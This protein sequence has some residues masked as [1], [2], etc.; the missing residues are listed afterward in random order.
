MAECDRLMMVAGYDGAAQ[1]ALARHMPNPLDISFG[2][3]SSFFESAATP[4]G[5]VR[6]CFRGGIS[7]GQAHTP[8]GLVSTRVRFF[9]I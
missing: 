6:A 7:Q 4:V 5:V 3:V 1:A 9:I 8:A 2:A